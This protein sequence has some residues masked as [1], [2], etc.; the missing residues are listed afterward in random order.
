MPL[1]KFHLKKGFRMSLCPIFKTIVL[2]R[3]IFP[4]RLFTKKKFEIRKNGLRINLEGKN[5]ERG[6]SEE[7]MRKELI[8]FNRFFPFY[9]ISRAKSTKN[10]MGLINE[11]GQK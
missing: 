2:F 1:L 4:Y 9:K 6:K 5:V 7:I 10:Y 3:L 11:A 8:F